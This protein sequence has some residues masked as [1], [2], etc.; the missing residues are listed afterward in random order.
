MPLSKDLLDE[1]L[2]GVERADGQHTEPVNI[3]GRSPQVDP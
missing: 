2:K 3:V 1:H